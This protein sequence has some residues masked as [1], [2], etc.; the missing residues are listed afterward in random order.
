MA[1][2]DLIISIE[3][4]YSQDA[5][6]FL[7]FLKKAGKNYPV[8][9]SYRALKPGHFYLTI[10]GTPGAKIDALFQELILNKGLYYY[11][12]S[13]R[14]RSKIISKVIVPIFQELLESRFDITYPRLLRKH[15]LGKISE[16]FFP[17]NF[18]NFH[19]HQYE[20]LFRKWDI[21]LIDNYN[22]VKDIDDLLTNFMLVNLGFKRGQKSPK[23]KWLVEESARKNLIFQKGTKKN[24][25]NFHKWRTKGLH[26]L[27]RSL[28]FEDISG[29]ALNMYFYFEYFDEFE[30]SQQVKTVKLNGRLYRRIRYG[31]EKWVDE[32][33]NPYLDDKT[34]QP[35]DIEKI[36]C[37]DCFAIRGQLHCFGC[38][39]EQCPRCKGQALG[40]DCEQDND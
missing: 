7:Q 25:N 35:I 28:K 32:N 12:C 4:R 23:F 40:C 20:K 31:N 21:K 38:D 11:S 19:A 39:M 2:Y 30:Q 3:P 34:G 18:K 10:D 9:I 26:R 22:F 8:L 33:G 6:S 37:H 17:G 24:F 27:D 36:P 14:S 29:A 16:E 15:I 13:L 5:R 1:G